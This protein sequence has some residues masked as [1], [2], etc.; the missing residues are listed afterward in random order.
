MKLI[1]SGKKTDAAV[2]ATNHA[3]GFKIWKSAAW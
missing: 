2:V 3:F 1:F